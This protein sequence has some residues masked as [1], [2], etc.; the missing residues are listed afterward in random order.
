M[1]IRVKLLGG[2][3]IIALIGAFLGVLGLYSERRLT[4]A[5][6]EMLGLSGTSA[7]ISSILSSHYIWRHSLSETVYT[8]VTFTGSLNSTTCSLGNWLN[9]DEVKE[10][11]DSEV[12]TLLH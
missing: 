7:K 11:T 1:K 8:G 10:V 4:N 6:E 12:L 2:F 9:S 5:S 3:I